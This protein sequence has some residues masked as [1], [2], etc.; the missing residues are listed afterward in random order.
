MSIPRCGTFQY[1]VTVP[2][3]V[4]KWGRWT[5]DLQKPIELTGDDL[6]DDRLVGHSPALEISDAGIAPDIPSTGTGRARPKVWGSRTLLRPR[7]E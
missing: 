4:K 7:P 3:T 6:T 1:V 5:V 2:E